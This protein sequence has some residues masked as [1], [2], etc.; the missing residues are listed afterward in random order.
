MWT[1]KDFQAA[2]RQ[3]LAAERSQSFS[4]VADGSYQVR[5]VGQVRPD[6]EL[7]VLSNIPTRALA[8]QECDHLR[9]GRRR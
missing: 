6:R 7:E 5:S 3:V 9:K 4:I 8:E 1:P 2:L